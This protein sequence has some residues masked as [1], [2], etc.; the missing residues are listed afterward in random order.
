MSHDS[1]WCV[2]IR[3][4]RCLVAASDHT[5]RPQ[6]WTDLD[7]ALTDLS[8]PT[9]EWQATQTEHICRACVL[10]RVCQAAG[11]EWTPWQPLTLPDPAGEELFF[12]ICT[13]C[14]K[15]NVLPVEF[16]WPKAPALTVQP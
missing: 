10:A 3:C 9:F 7:Q 11:H 2:T 13:R 8:G 14:G 15:D 16:I 12:A 1:T 6:H 4:D 5:G